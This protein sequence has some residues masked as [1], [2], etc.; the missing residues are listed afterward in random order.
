MTPDFSRA[1]AQVLASPYFVSPPSGLTGDALR[2]WWDARHA[3]KD[4]LETAVQDADD[5]TQLPAPAKAVWD[6]AFDAVVNAMAQQ[7]LYDRLH[8]D[9]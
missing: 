2:D 6:K 8:G 9:Y 3:E 4:K 5:E 1:A 7:D